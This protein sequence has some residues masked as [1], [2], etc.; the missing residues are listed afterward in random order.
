MTKKSENGMKKPNKL[1]LRFSS[2]LTNV[3]NAMSTI[4]ATQLTYGG[5]YERKGFSARF[6][7]WQRVFTLL[8]TDYRK[9]ERNVM[10]LYFDTYRSQLYDEDRQHEATELGDS[11][12]GSPLYFNR[13]RQR[14]SDKQLSI[15]YHAT[16]KVPGKT[17]AGY[18]IPNRNRSY[19]IAIM[20][21]SGSAHMLAPILQNQETEIFEFPP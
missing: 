6:I 20:I 11:N 14:Q 12:T 8:F 9:H 18:Y 3:P 4:C 15:C 16:R 21:Q 7:L 17:I 5:S 19:N 13:K 10:V 2:T 1:P